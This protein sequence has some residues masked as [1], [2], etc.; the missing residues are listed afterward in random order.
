MTLCKSVFFASII[1][2][3]VFLE[4][5]MANPFSEVNLR[6]GLIAAL[7]QHPSILDFYE[8]NKYEFIWLENNELSEQRRSELINSLQSASFHGL[9]IKKYGVN[10]LVSKLTSSESL[11]KNSIKIIRTRK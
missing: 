4:Q 3:A 10:K 7:K 1:F 11:Y 5:V 8:E 2:L 6:A 9:P